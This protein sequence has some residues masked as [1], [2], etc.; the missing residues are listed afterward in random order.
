MKAERKD[1][2]FLLIGFLVLIVGTYFVS[3]D[4]IVTETA[5]VILTGV[6]LIWYAWETNQLRRETQRQTEIQLRPFVIFRF[7]NEVF[8]VSNLGNGPALNVRIDDVRISK[9]DRAVIRFPEVVPVLLVHESIPFPGE[10]ILQGNTV[11]SESSAMAHLNPR[12]A[13]LRLPVQIHF[14]NVEMKS[15]T[16]KL[17]VS[18]GTIEIVGGN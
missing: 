4:V 12:F 14:N 8:Q 6:V 1:L 2:W 9:E 15:Y 7:E 13:S 18:P 10:Y 17:V 11:D 16:V 3:K 5:T